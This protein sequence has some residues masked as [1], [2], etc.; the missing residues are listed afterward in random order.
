[1]TVKKYK[2]CIVPKRVQVTTKTTNT[3]SSTNDTMSIA[4]ENTVFSLIPKENA[5]ISVDFF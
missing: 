5:T 3:W 4:F 2:H 1:M